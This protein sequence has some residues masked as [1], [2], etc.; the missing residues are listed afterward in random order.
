MLLRGKPGPRI[1]DLSQ[2][3]D[4]RFLM[5]QA[6]DLNLRLMKWRMWPALD[7]E[8][9]AGTRCLLFGAGTLGCAVARTLLGWGVRHI[10]FIDNG[11]VSYSNPARQCLF[12]FADCEQR[13]FKAEAAAMH[14]KQIFPD[15]F[16]EGMVLNIPM[17]GHPLTSPLTSE[18]T[19]EATQSE[20]ERDFRR[21]EELVSSHDVCFALTDSREARWLPTVMCAAHGKLMINAALG[22]DSYLVMHH[23]NPGRASGSRG[24]SSS[25]SERTGCY[26]C[27]DVVA[28]TNSQKDRSMDQMCTVT[29]P[30]LSFIAAAL[31]VELMVALLFQREDEVT[32][33]DAHPPPHQIRGSVAGF[34]QML[35]Q[36]SP[37]PATFCLIDAS[38]DMVLV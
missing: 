1:A 3:L 20:D 2:A 37:H 26:F 10:T 35:L 38:S 22:F 7:T 17:P 28:A 33:T 8:R 23:G 32:A 12:E 29:R 18:T 14:L 15:V 16:S 25:C 19:Y 24:S 13:R 34:T 27:N 36:V 6:V 31:S 30:G 4:S 11:R 9:L 21:L 5:S